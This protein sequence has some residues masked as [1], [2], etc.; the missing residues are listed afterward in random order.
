MKVL[1]IL[2][3][4]LTWGVSAQKQISACVLPWPKQDYI[5][6]CIKNTRYVIKREYIGGYYVEKMF[7]YSKNAPKCG[8]KFVDKMKREYFAREAKKL[9]EQ[10]DREVL[11]Y[12]EIKIAA[13]VAQIKKKKIQ[14]SGELPTPIMYDSD[15]QAF[16]CV[17]CN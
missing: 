9:Q 3:L 8:C 13:E 6:V 5:R 14:H 15:K 11:M 1:L 16:T 2:M 17:K 7:S 12:G 10:L 4:A